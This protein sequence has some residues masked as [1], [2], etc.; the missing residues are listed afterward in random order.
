MTQ[1][2]RPDLASVPLPAGGY[3]PLVTWLRLDGGRAVRG[4]VADV[5]VAPDR[6]NRWTGSDVL[7]APA[8]APG[9]STGELPLQFNFDCLAVGMQGSMLN[10]P[11]GDDTF[12]G[13]SNVE[14]RLQ[15]QGSNEELFLVGESGGFAPFSTLF[16]PAGAAWRPLY[17]VIRTGER[18]NLTIRNRSTI[19]SFRV[20]FML[21][22]RVLELRCPPDFPAVNL[23]GAR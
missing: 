19:E 16:P 6:W 12:R 18:W 10:V 3:A 15:I 20:D 14:G 22:L 7:L 17:R 23:E 9:S 2:T 11:A 13:L 5:V 21:A 1:P 4:N 8:P